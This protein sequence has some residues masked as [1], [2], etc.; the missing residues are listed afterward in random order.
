MD[1]ITLDSILVDED[2]INVIKIDVEGGEPLVL[3]GAENVL[4]RTEIVILEA[5]NPSSF[6]LA[7]KIL[8]KHSFRPIKKLNNNVAFAKI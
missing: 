5:T 8:A 2:R 6:S 4:K 1:A 7:S 3:K